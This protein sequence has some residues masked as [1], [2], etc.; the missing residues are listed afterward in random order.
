MVKPLFD[1]LV[2]IAP[3]L[4]HTLSLI[5]AN[6]VAWRAVSEEAAAQAA[7]APPPPPRRSITGAAVPRQVS[8]R[9]VR[10][11]AGAPDVPA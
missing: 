11:S 9:A 6:L 10:K 7:A 3:R 4:R 8:D 5:D 1:V 2:D